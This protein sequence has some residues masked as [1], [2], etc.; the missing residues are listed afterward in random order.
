M[1]PDGSGQTTLVNN[2]FN[3][4]P[5]WQPIPNPENLTPLPATNIR[6]S[7]YNVTAPGRT[8]AIPLLSKQIP[9]LPARFVPVSPIYDVRTSASYAGTITVSF[10]VPSI[11]HAT[12]CSELRVMHFTYG[13]WNEGYYPLPV[14]NNGVCTVSQRVYSLSPFMVARFNSN[15]RT[16]SGTITYG[17]TPTGQTA[18]LVSDVSLTAAGASEA[19]TSANSNGTYSL[20]N[21]LA[22]EQY[23][24]TA[25]KSGNVNAISPF[26]ATMVLRHVAANGQGPNALNPNQRIAADTNGDG[27][28]SPFDATLILRYV[29]VG[30]P[31]ANTGHVGN[32]KFSPPRRNYESLFNSLA[33][34]DYEAILVGEVN[35]NWTPPAPGSIATVENRT[36]IAPAG[37]KATQ[38]H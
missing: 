18:K 38:K 29:A 26:D 35:G 20:E 22:N 32:W 25:T 6:V 9:Q 5:M 19:A 28:I 34:Q 14:F 1:N 3:N 10:D 27:N 17:T 33:G 11:A 36:K 2:G 12:A 30:A 37:E 21:L 15:P 16:L 13:A 31:N 8:V 24:I 23:T 7:F 4:I